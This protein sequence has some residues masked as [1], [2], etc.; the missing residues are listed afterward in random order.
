MATKRKQESMVGFVVNMSPQKKKTVRLSLQ[1]DGDTT[2]KAI[3]FDLSKLAVL[4]QKQQSGEPIKI[5]NAIIEP[6]PSNKNFAEII[7][8]STAKLEDP[9]PGEITFGR[10]FNGR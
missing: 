7:I 6:A 5:K 4:K 3:L 8:N 1:V 10:I 9:Q 2:K